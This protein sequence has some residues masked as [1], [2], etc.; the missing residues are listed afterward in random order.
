VPELA[1][2]A[3]DAGVVSRF[4]FSAFQGG[5]LQSLLAQRA[6]DTLVFSGVETDVCVLATALQAIDRGYRVVVVDE[7]VASSNEAGHT[8]AMTGIFPRFDQQVEIVSVSDLLRH[9]G[10]DLNPS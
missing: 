4:V 1:R 9:W 5:E 2:I 10:Q 7:A 6:T 8:A 3:A